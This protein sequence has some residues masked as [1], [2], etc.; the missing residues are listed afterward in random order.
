MKDRNSP[1]Q[2][3]ALVVNVVPLKGNN[4]CRVEIKYGAKEF[5]DE[6]NVNSSEQRQKLISQA[7]KVLEVPFESLEHLQTE[8]PK[9]LE[10][11]IRRIDDEASARQTDHCEDSVNSKSAKAL[12]ET[13]QEVIDD[14]MRFLKSNDLLQE[15]RQDFA[16]LGIVGEELLATT[17]YL[18]AISCKMNKPLAAIVKAASS[19][20]KSFVSNMVA[21]MAPPEQVLRATDMTPQAMYYLPP[22]SLKHKLVVL[23]EKQHQGSDPVNDVNAGLALREMLSSGKLRKLVPEKGPEGMT[24]RI[25]EQEGPIALIETTTQVELLEEDENRL[26]QLTTDETSEQTARIHQRQSL[27]AAGLLD[28][29]AREA[30]LLKHQTAQRLLKNVRVI[31]PFAKHLS[32]P[33]GRVI[34]RRAFAQLLTCTCV[35]AFLRQMQKREKNGSISATLIDYRVAYDVMYPILRRSFSPINERALDLY[36]AIINNLDSSRVYFT[37]QDCAGWRELV[38]RKRRIVSIF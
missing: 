10:E 37:R 15:L 5:I 6:R 16:S 12:D 28:E 25:I 34:A 18:V 21:D 35:V 3:L 31:I 22:G 8:L 32:V 13:P 19:S 11:A 36:R 33:T 4:R 17:L 27:E 29:S 23:A 1:E 30:I 7:A 14:A 26:L 9:L 20:G 2:E 24:T 38:R